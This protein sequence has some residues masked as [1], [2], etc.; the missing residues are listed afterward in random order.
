M[1]GM[2]GF[3]Y[4]DVIRNDDKFSSNVVFILTTSND[5]NDRSK[6]YHKQIAG[7]M[8]KSDVGPQFGNLSRLLMDYSSAI[9][10]PDL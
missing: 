4:L 10:L 2:N 7:Y 8:V 9:T 5:D 6:A 1:P 3:E